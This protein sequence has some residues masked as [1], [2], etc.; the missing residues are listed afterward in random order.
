MHYH[1]AI[2]LA[3]Q[4]IRQACS[5]RP[6]FSQQSWLGAFYYRKRCIQ[7]RNK[8]HW[9]YLL[10]RLAHYSLLVRQLVHLGAT[11]LLIRL[12]FPECHRICL[13]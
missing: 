2:F 10:S 3:V 8:V 1:Q 11:F 4:L 12:I 6:S 9:H 7:S 13:A 5:Y